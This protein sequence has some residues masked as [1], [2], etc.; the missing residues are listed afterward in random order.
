MKR[1]F[2]QS[3]VKQVL[4]LELLSID[5]VFC[6]LGQMDA[7]NFGQIDNHL[8]FQSITP[9]ACKAIAYF[10]IAAQTMID[11]NNFQF[12][13]GRNKLI[14]HFIPLTPTSD[15]IKISVLQR[16][17]QFIPSFIQFEKWFSAKV[18]WTMLLLEIQQKR[19]CNRESS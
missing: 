13:F 15:F 16:S 1:L 8:N 3:T 10:L 18:S 19:T 14:H 6:C 9:E 5:I 11:K 7:L 2:C 12:I 4:V 17:N